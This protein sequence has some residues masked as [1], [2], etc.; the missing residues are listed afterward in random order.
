M[1]LGSKYENTFV[2]SDGNQYKWQILEEGG[3]GAASLDPVG[4][5]F[6]ETRY[7]RSDSDE[8][9]P[10][11]VS[12]TT[13]SLYDN[14][15]GDL[16]SDVV[17]QLSDNNEDRYVL[18]I[19]DVT[20]SNKTKWQGYIKRGSA[21]KDED[22]LPT[23]SLT[24]TDGIDM[25][26]R[27]RFV[28]TSAT[29]FGEAED[30]YTGRVT[31]TSLIA[32]VLGK[33][34]FDFNININSEHY[35]RLR[36]AALTANGGFQLD[37]DDNPW[38]FVYVDRNTYKDKQRSDGE[39]D[40]PIYTESVLRDVLTT[41]GCTMYQWDGEWWI[42]QVNNRGDSSIRWF[43]YDSTGAPIGTPAYT[44]ATDH[45]VTP[46]T[47][48]TDR[49]RGGIA[50][51]PPHDAVTVGFA[52]GEYKFMPNPG[53]DIRAYGTVQYDPDYWT[54]TNRGSG[55][56]EN[57]GRGDGQYIAA[58]V[59]TRDL[60]DVPTSATGTGTGSVDLFVSN[61]ADNAGL[62]LAKY[63]REAGTVDGSFS[64]TITQMDID[65][66]AGNF[67]A[68]D[69]GLWVEDAIGTLQRIQ[70]SQD[71]KP[72]DTEIN[73]DPVNVGILARTLYVK[74]T[75]YAEMTSEVSISDGENVEIRAQFLPRLAGAE[76]RARIFTLGQRRNAYI[77]VK[78]EGDA[79]TYYLTRGIVEYTWETT[80]AWIALPVQSNDWNNVYIRVYDETPIQGNVTITVGPSVEYM[81]TQLTF[82]SPLIPHTF[83]E[84]RW[85]NVDVLPV[86]SFNQPNVKGS[87]RTVYDSAQGTE[88]SRE[89]KVSVMVGDAA[90]NPALFGMTLDSDGV[91]GTTDWEEAPVGV[92]ESNVD[93]ETLLAKAMLRS[94]RAPR[95]AH[96]AEYYGLTTLLGPYH[97]LSRGGSEYAPSSL[98]INWN[99][100]YVSGS[101]YKVTETGFNDGSALI[102][103]AAGLVGAKGGVGADTAGFFTSI[104]NVLFADGSSAITRTDTAITAGTVTSISVEAITEPIFKAGDLISII[105]PALDFVQAR[106]VNDQDALATSLSIEDIDNPGTGVTF[107]V[108]FAAP[109]AI[110]FLE[111]ELLTLARL[112]EQGFAVT[113]LGENLGQ[114]NET[115]GP[116][117]YTTLDVANW[118]ISV[119]ADTD[120]YIT[121]SD[122][123]LKAVTLAAAAPRGSTSI[124]FHLKGG[125]IGDAVP[126]DVTSGGAIKPTGT[127]NRADFQVTAD[128]ITAYLGN[129]GDVIA[130]VTG[131]SFDG[132]NTSVA[133]SG[134][135]VTV[136]SGE[137][138]LFYT[139]GGTVIKAIVNAT[140]GSSPIVLTAASGDQTG[141]ITSGDKVV[142]GSVTGLRID[143]D[144][145]DVRADEIRSSNYSAGSVGWLIDSIGN[146]YFNNISARGSI[147]LGAGS[148]ADWSYVTGANKPDD[149][150]TQGATW[151]VNIVSQPTDA[152]ILNAQQIWSEIS[153][154][155]KPED[156]AT[157][158]A[159]WDSNVDNLPDGASS[160][161]NDLAPR[162]GLN[163]TNTYL[164]YYDGS[165]WKTFMEGTTGNF[166][167]GG[168]A[169][170][171]Q[172]NA[173]TN[174]LTI[175]GSIRA[176][177][178]FIG[179]GSSGFTI[180]STYFYNG[181]TSLTDANAGVYIGTNGIALGAS[182]V[183]KVTD[184]GV[185][186]ASSATISGSFNVSTDI[187][188][189]S[190]GI[191]IQSGSGNV[192]KI[193]WSDGGYIESGGGP[194]VMTI[195]PNTSLGIVA[196]GGTLFNPGNIR[197]ANTTAPAG[198][199]STA[200]IYSVA[201]D[202]YTK[203]GTGTGYK[204][205]TA[206]S[207]QTTTFND[208][209]FRVVD[210]GTQTEYRQ[211][212][213]T[214]T[215]GQIT[216]V[217]GF[218]SWTAVAVN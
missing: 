192:N 150:A 183:F 51:A 203:N 176:N 115:K 158:G 70:L 190:G 99:R 118:G 202:L 193:R 40:R 46:S 49:T 11:L 59:Q 9:S 14:S 101:W 162:T 200:S 26:K 23:I 38:D 149:N 62:S 4:R 78:L 206:E 72:G 33:T 211:R 90:Y 137:S 128:A 186:T 156:N 15:S 218:G 159:D 7:S 139:K 138:I 34:G 17:E 102:R 79:G 106:I 184:A 134:L 169:G 160:L 187:T 10:Y 165:N 196:S 30:V 37:A 55:R 201:G 109:S 191:L 141:N 12:Q 199:A 207:G 76:S 117:T 112:G 143:M 215:N 122:E 114:I 29:V 16:F 216:A 25:L 119:A 104:G 64:G 61:W 157:E 31:Y 6:I 113:V 144:G 155:G 71:L 107:D 54:I 126:L 13:I 116:G 27:R 136:E 212:T 74:K 88:V 60:S 77:Q 130:T 18:R 19:I 168:T 36:G 45:V 42:V 95:E 39:R 21:S 92:T 125:E 111:Q 8:Y 47:S 178:G 194:G 63:L 171:L 43:N 204:I 205:L 213:I 80:V 93:H 24:A 67:M 131:S 69:E 133:V 177:T 163:L 41:W 173:E 44:D 85:D 179:N 20:D 214:V 84:I 32:T 22:G 188:I 56:Y 73:F 198:Q 121:Q 120:V 217:G 166:Y 182:S 153:G 127:V 66:W 164:G 161:K 123:S 96:S 154:T 58:A 142:P 5:D 68:T 180:T 132:T 89:R 170:R 97:V 53:F 145:I 124:S 167:L 3:S 175:S 50:I 110:Y 48:K 103:D 189:D 52:H 151:G 100:E 148:D 2:A 81:P 82:N 94:L 152:A 105:S 98:D 146:A 195:A 129:P 172:W 174:S 208:T 135:G 28:S 75:S 83:D 185:L 147:I 197:L 210:G 87:S 91:L 181:K 108:E 57:I 140:T 65:P 209:E 86:T 35:P 1:A